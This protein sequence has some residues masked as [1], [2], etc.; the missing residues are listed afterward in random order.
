MKISTST[1]WCVKYFRTS[2][3]IKGCVSQRRESMK[4]HKDTHYFIWLDTDIIFDERTLSYVENSIIGIKDIP[5][6][7]ITPELVRIWDKTWDILVNKNYIKEKVGYQQKAD[8]YECSGLKGDV[9]L[10]RVENT[11]LHNLDS[12]L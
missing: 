6:S 10:E 8:P 2:D 5:Y 11:F 7:I 1:D 9:S 4:N 3:D 12:N